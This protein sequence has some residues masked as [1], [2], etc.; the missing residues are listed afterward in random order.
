MLFLHIYADRLRTSTKA[1]MKLH[2]N[3]CLSDSC[4]LCPRRRIVLQIVVNVVLPADKYWHN[5][6]KS[7]SIL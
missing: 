3:F 7:E 5:N 4:F 6:C 1:A 2:G